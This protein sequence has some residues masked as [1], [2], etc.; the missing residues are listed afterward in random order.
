MRERLKENLSTGRL[1]YASNIDEWI[2]KH[3][4]SLYNMRN[5]KVFTE[6][7]GHNEVVHAFYIG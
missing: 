2:F 7:Q 4:K 5:E 6:F 1:T 3:Y